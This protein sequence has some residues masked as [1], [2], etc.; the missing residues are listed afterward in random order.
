M[1]PSS[2][3]T[4]NS[5]ASAQT[6]AAGMPVPTLS[7]TGSGGRSDVRRL[8]SDIHRVGGPDDAIHLSIG[9]PRL[10]A[11]NVAL[12]IGRSSRQHYGDRHDARQRKRALYQASES[13]SERGLPLFSHLARSPQKKGQ[14]VLGDSRGQS[15]SCSGLCL[16]QG[17][18]VNVCMC[19]TYFLDC[20]LTMKYA[21]GSYSTVAALLSFREDPLVSARAIREI[22]VRSGLLFQD[23]LCTL[24]SRARRV[25]ASGSVARRPYSTPRLSQSRFR[26]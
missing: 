12:G 3:Q 26:C 14:S 8:A 18:P 21:N 25:Q 23:G 10:F 20:L 11:W 5:A 4:P 6:L 13:L 19:L 1:P 15:P 24:R 2:R 17:N 22:R 7:S 16:R 9:H